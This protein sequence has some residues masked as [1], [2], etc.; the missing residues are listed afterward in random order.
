MEASTREAHL[1]AAGQ[2]WTARQALRL[3]PLLLPLLGLWLLIANPQLDHTWEHQAVHFWL[4]VAAALVSVILGLWVSESARRH[5]DARLLLVSLTFLASAGFLLLHALATPTV[6]L[7]GRNTGFVIATPIGLALGALFAAASSTRLRPTVAATVLRWQGVLRGGLLLVMVAWAAASL[8][9]IPPFD[10]ELNEDA[11]HGLVQVL[12]VAGVALYALAAFL[13]AQLPRRGSWRVPLSV[14]AAFVLLAEAM[15]AI[16][17]SRNWHVS[18]WEW[19]VLMVAAFGLVAWSAQTEY[20]RDGAR[21]QAFDA[22]VLEQTVQRIHEQY[23]VAVAGLVS[24]IR[25][26]PAA[27]QELAAR[28]AGSYDLTAAQADVLDRA[29]HEIAQLLGEQEIEVGR[30]KELE[31]ELNL[32]RLI[33]QHFLPAEPP[34]LEGW[35]LEA[36]YYPARAV[37]GDFYDFL[38]LPGDRVGI[39]IGD[40]TDKGAP[41]ALVMASTLSILRSEAPQLVSPAKVLQRANDLLVTQTVPTM[42]V[43]CF[44]AVLE[45]Q[46]GRL[47]FANAGH[48]VP[49]AR[50]PHGGEELWAAGM[51]LGLM[52]DMQYEEQE[53]VLEPGTSLLL[54]S[55]GL[56]EA[57]G[58]GRE[59]FGF[60]R[61]A[62]LVRW[63]SGDGLIPLL[64]SELHRFTGDGWEQEDDVTLLTIQRLAGDRPA[65]ADRL[66]AAARG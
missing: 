41:A 55:D 33:Q 43:T 35:R 17:F 49:Y 47:R 16:A 1:S 64:M 21:S 52:P 48:P 36:V 51:P 18:W 37:G 61:L 44:Y 32:A 40:V 46:T 63:S 15:I 14:I 62:D 24:E 31:N 28:V 42:F 8:L 5:S 29:A 2:P 7:E 65:D 60:P 54:H 10:A 56:A 19:H 9:R 13:Y 26:Q 12:T 23:G 66:E 27:A 4:V 57:H 34:N 25:R 53:V 58:A 45:P 39:V 22:I 3:A 6:L 20:R 50:T 30:R 59:L 11:A 38:A